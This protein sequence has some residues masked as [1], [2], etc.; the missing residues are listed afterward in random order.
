M[1]SLIFVAAF[2]GFYKNE[3][4]K[5]EEKT[6]K[7]PYHN[8]IEPVGIII[9]FYDEE[10]FLGLDFNENKALFIFDDVVFKALKKGFKIDYSYSFSQ[11][12]LENLVDFL[13]GI[14]VDINGENLNLTGNQIIDWLSEDLSDEKLKYLA[15]NI[16]KK[17]AKQGMSNTALEK[18]F[19]NNTGTLSLKSC[20]LFLNNLSEVFKNPYFI[21]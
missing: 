7:I 4:V 16:S 20:Y 15:E 14:E 8:E 10:I 13:G 11:E 1:I 19:E 17:I 6:Q 12:K 18:L 2:C 21:E 9:S 3:V 5:T